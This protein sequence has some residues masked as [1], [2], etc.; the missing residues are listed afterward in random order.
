MRVFL[1]TVL[2]LHFMTFNASG[3]N[4]EA[5]DR[6]EQL[7]E[8]YRRLRDSLSLLHPFIPAISSVMIQKDQAEINLFNS[9]VTANRYRGDNGDIAD[10][11]ARQTYFYSTLQL[12]YGISQKSKLNI[13]LDINTIAG[14]VDLDRTSSVFKVFDSHV[15]GNSKYA[16]AVTSI[17]PRLRWR[18]LKKSY[19]FTIQT[20]VGIPISISSEKQPVLGQSQF[21]LLTQFLYNQPLSKRLFLFTQYSFQYNFKRDYTPASIISPLTFYLSF[22]IPKKVILFGLLNY[23]PIYSHYNNWTYRYTFQPGGGLQYQISRSFL[24]NGYYTND[25][26]GKNYPDFSS[27]NISL[28][29]V[30]H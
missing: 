17:A 27:Y 11:G 19:N 6:Y 23:V 18:P 7:E 1:L 5:D 22:L 26:K 4:K 30:T 9:L 24:I 12:T 16:K 28:R 2:I 13:G 8:K 14:R 3:Q 20:S 25:I 21:Y 29:F 10:L 15:E